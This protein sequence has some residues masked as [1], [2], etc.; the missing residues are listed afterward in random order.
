MLL[1]KNKLYSNKELA[2]WFEISEGAFK[3]QKKKK[4]EY[5]SLFADFEIRKGKV[6]GCCAICLD[7][8]KARLEKNKTDIGFFLLFFSIGVGP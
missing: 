4:L 5:L 8:R 2:A 3:N 1:E 7:M 6:C